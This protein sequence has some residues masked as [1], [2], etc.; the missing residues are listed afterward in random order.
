MIAAL[1]DR[2]EKRPR[3]GFAGFALLHA[4]L[5]TALPS[6]LYPNLPL[7]LIEAMTYGR[8]WQ[9]GYDKLP[10]LPWFLAEAVYRATGVD[11]SLYALSQAAVI[12]A[13]IA[14]WMTARPMVGAIGALAAILIIDGMHYFTLSAA[15]FNHNVV[16]LPF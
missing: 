10:P 9:L 5:W 1:I 13:F 11:T 2:L 7:D 4:A 16:E 8:E 12:V 3:E 6:A 15:K 14:V